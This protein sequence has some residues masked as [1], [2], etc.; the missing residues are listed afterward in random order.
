MLQMKCVIQTSKIYFPSI[1]VEFLREEKKKKHKNN[2]E[3]ADEVL[4]KYLLKL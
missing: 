1:I 3:I 4:R 2:Y